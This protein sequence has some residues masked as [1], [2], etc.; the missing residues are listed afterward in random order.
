MT[1]APLPTLD[2]VV[3]YYN[4]E[5][6]L[7]AC[8]RHLEADQDIQSIILVDNNS[9]DSS[10]AIAEAF[11]RRD[12]RVVRVQE[13]RRGVQFARDAGIARSSADIVARIDADTRV[14]PGWAG[15][16]RRYYATHP[17][18][19]AASGA[20]EFYDLPCRRLTNL[21]VWLF[22]V[23]SNYLIAGNYGLYGANMSIRRDIWVTIYDNVRT[24]AGTMEDLS[25]SLALD[26]SNY[27]VGYVRE[28]LAHVSGRRMRTHPR[29]FKQYND[30]WWR[31]YQ[32]YGHRTKAT[33]ARLIA[34]VGNLGHRVAY[35]VLRFH[36]A[37]TGTFRVAHFKKTHEDRIIP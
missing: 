29:N 25:I 1:R 27:K 23:E 14:Q 36:D 35:V 5:D 34:A 24:D 15:T 22:L 26:Q 20:Y 31:T 13:A 18:I 4:E 3:P 37:K 11:A 7:D 2:V 9:T 19:A 8:L 21:I 17:D 30:Q 10:A 32:A 28:A 33:I 6:E 12:T 16:L